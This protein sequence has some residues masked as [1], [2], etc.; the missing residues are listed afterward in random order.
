VTCFGNPV[1]PWRLDRAQVQRD[2]I[3][4]GL[5]S[6]D[7]W[8]RFFVTVPGDIQWAETEDYFELEE[9]AALRAA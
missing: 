7:E 3:E 9:P 5:G 1:G 4:Q 6:Y 2:A 8:G